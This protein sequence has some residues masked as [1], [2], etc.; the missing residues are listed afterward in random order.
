[1]SLSLVAGM[2][3][4][5]CS[6]VL[7][8]EVPSDSIISWCVSSGASVKEFVAG[9]DAMVQ[10][11]ESGGLLAAYGATVWIGLVTVAYSKFAARTIDAVLECRLLFTW[12]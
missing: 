3:F 4:V 1:M 9:F 8:R 12:I 7:P 11:N 2:A 10:G 5:L 6:S